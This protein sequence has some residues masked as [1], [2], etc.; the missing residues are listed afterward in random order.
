[1]P[2]SYTLQPLTD[3][4]EHIYFTATGQEIEIII[5]ENL[6]SFNRDW[7]VMV[8]LEEAILLRIVPENSNVTILVD[9]DIITRPNDLFYLINIDGVNTWKA[10]RAGNFALTTSNRQII[11]APLELDSGS[12]VNQFIGA[13]GGQQDIILPDP[14]STNDRYVIKNIFQDQFHINI[15]E[16]LGGQPI[17]RLGPS[18]LR[19]IAECIY[20]GVEWQ[21][22]LY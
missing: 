17:V 5:P 3:N 22:I 1:M 15:K 21:I 19:Y 20:D 6:G 16:T 18:T 11:N 8:S 12:A 14:P 7:S 10:I 13:A 9:Q 4:R 2:V